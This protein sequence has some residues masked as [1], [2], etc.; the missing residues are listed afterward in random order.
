MGRTPSTWRNWTRN[1]TAHLEPDSVALPKGGSN[2]KVGVERSHRTDDEE[3]YI[4]FLERISTEEEFLRYA[5]RWQFHYD[6]HRL[7]FGAGMDGLSPLGKLRALGLELPEEFAAFP[8]VVLDE[9]A[10]TWA[11]KGGHDVLAYYSFTTCSTL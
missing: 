8:V 1:S 11:T 4:P 2:T 9:V 5:Q 3:F 7:H 6:V 10:M